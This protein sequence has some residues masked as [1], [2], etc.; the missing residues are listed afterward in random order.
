LQSRTGT[1]K[2]AG[3]PP[4]KKTRFF[5][6]ARTSVAL[7]T[8]A[9]C[10][11]SSCAASCT[12]ISSCTHR[13]SLQNDPK[14]SNILQNFG[15]LILCCISTNTADSGHIIIPLWPRRGRRPR[16]KSKT[17]KSPGWPSRK[18]RPGPRRRVETR[19]ECKT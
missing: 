14:S 9:C 7:Y 12:G 6:Q 3:Y 4:K 13:E 11:C 15:G 1:P 10:S 17:A 18:W 19:C 16:W 5:L 2:S 8:P